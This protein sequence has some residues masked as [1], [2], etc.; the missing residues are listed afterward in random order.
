MG[1]FK[2]YNIQLLPLD[3]GKTGMV[4]VDGYRKLLLGLR[5]S[6]S[7]ARRRKNLESIAAPLR[8]DMFIVPFQVY[9][10][11]E[12]DAASGRFL[13]FNHIDALRD[14]FTGEETQKVG[15]GI[16]NKRF[17]FEFVFDFR[18]HIMAIADKTSLPS[19]APLCKALTLLFADQAKDLFA[20]HI[21]R[22]TELT[23]GDSLDAVLLADGYK[24]VE[25]D[26]T[27]SNSDDY[28]DGME[29]ELEEEL[30]GKNIHD[31]SYTEK[32]E[33][34]SEMTQISR[35]AQAMLHLAIKY[36]N[37]SV[38]YIKDKS[39]HWYHMK[40]FPVRLNLKIESDES[41]MDYFGRIKNSIVVAAARARRKLVKRKL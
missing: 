31:A 12:S 30:R 2:Y 8:N 37:A 3:S 17:E 9:V 22:V 23:E 11:G 6:L 1:W 10:N 32:S 19:S 13:K 26:V 4:G 15:R 33:K 24:R 7:K 16:T 18:S 25:V 36:G 41:E 14:L 39:T 29:K 40:D 21:V 28:E 34:D 35:F 38:R 5:E 27:F 20:E